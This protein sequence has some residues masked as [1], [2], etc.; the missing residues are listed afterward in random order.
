MSWRTGAMPPVDSPTPSRVPALAR[1]KGRDASICFHEPVIRGVVF[2]L[3]SVTCSSRL[4]ATKG[5]REAPEVQPAGLSTGARGPWG[6]TALEGMAGP[7]GRA[8]WP[9]LPHHSDFWVGGVGSALL[10]TAEEPPPP[11]RAG[12]GR[13]ASVN[14]QNAGPWLRIGWR[15]YQPWSRVSEGKQLSRREPPP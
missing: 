6:D 5:A 10:S 7:S 8:V 13:P 9:P 14:A 3:S 11:G 1:G 12:G 15:G 4:W 2:S